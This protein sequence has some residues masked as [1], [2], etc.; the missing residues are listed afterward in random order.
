MPAPAGP[1]NRLQSGLHVF[2]GCKRHLRVGD[3]GVAAMV[4]IVAARVGERGCPGAACALGPADPGQAAGGERPG[5]CLVGFAGPAAGQ[6]SAIHLS[7]LSCR[8]VTDRDMK[9]T[10]SESGHG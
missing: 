7:T 2:A 1:A 8:K 10:V 5:A 9:S 4:E 6:S 3:R